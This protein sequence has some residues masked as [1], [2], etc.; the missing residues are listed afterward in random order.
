M[1]AWLSHTVHC[2]SAE[3]NC[4]DGSLLFKPL[5]LNVNALSVSI[6]V[7]R[8]FKDEMSFY[9]QGQNI[10]CHVCFFSALVTEH[11]TTFS[12]MCVSVWF[13]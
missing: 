3:C 10:L 6:I 8:A 11:F 1:S 2:V 5:G 12:I 9:F 7:F 13:R 4:F